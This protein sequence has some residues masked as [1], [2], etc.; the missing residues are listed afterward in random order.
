V[1]EDS[2]GLSHEFLAIMLGSRRAT[3]SRVAERLRKNGI[4]SY[5]LGSIRV[6]NRARLEAVACECY[7]SIRREFKQLNL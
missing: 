6:V 2:F 7:P 5:R 1:H 3:V 4:I